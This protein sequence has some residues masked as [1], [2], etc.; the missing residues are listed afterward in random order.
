MKDDIGEDI[1]ETPMIAIPCAR[2]KEPFGWPENETPPED[3]FCNRCK[4]WKKLVNAH[5]LISE[6]LNLI[7][8]I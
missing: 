2:C 7:D 4:A 5:L 3:G 8:E 1:P 6:A